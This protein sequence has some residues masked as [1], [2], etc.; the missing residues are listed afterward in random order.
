MVF[1]INTDFQYLMS[2]SFNFYH[3][4][5]NGWKKGLLSVH[6]IKVCYTF[7]LNKMYI[8]HFPCTLH[9]HLF[10]TCLICHVL[11]K[12]H[13]LPQIFFVISPHIFNAFA[14][15]SLI[16]NDLVSSPIWFMTATFLFWILFS[17]SIVIILILSFLHFYVFF[18]YLLPSLL[19]LIF[20]CQSFGIRFISC[21]Q[22]IV[23]IYYLALSESLCILMGGLTLLFITINYIYGFI[24]VISFYYFCLWDFLAFSY[25]AVFCLVILHF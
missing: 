6:G 19:F 11:S 3:C 18:Q 13:C 9:P 21:K 5:K 7:L 20:P 2:S 17:N 16:L 24:I 23:D 12:I 1:Y 15:N 22:N 4:F 8:S 10:F 25:Y 14:L